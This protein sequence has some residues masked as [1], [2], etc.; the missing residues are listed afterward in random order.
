MAWGYVGVSSVAT[1]AS[2]NIALT[3]PAG[4]ADGDL[5]IACIAYRSNAAFTPPSGAGWTLIEQQ[6]TGN[7][8]AA[9][10]A[11]IASGA[12][13]WKIRSGS[14][15]GTWTRTGG[16]I[17]LGRIIAYD[18]HDPSSPLNVHNSVTLAAGASTTSTLSGITTT[19]ANEL[20]VAMGASARASSFAS[21]DATDPAT[22]SGTGNQTGAPTAGTWLERA[23][24][25]SSTGAD[26]ALALFDGVRATAGATGNIIFNTNL[27]GRHALFAASFKLAPV[28]YTL[29]AD[30]GSFALTGVA[31][32]L[33]VG[34]KLTAE[35]GSFAL[36]GVA[37]DLVYDSGAGAYALTADAGSFALAGQAA[38]LLVGR[39]IAASAGAFT[40]T[41]RAAG[42]LHGSKLTASAG[43]F[44]LTGV[45]ADLT[46]GR[47]ITAAAGAFTLSG[48]A[49]G[50]LYGRRLTAGAGA[51]TLSG[52]AVTL[53]KGRTLAVEAG[54]FALT[55]FAA[56]LTRTR[57]LAAGVGAFALSGQAVGLLAGRKL[58]S[59]VGSYA[60]S[61]QSA[62]L[63]IGRRLAAEAGAFAV[64]GVDAALT[65]TP[66]SSPTL[67]AEPG[68]FVFVGG[69]AQL[70][71]GS[72][73]V[74]LPFGAGGGV[75]PSRKKL[76]QFLDELERS[77]E[78][79]ER[80]KVQPPRPAQK[81]PPSTT[82]VGPIHTSADDDEEALVWILQSMV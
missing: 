14:A 58:A 80:K 63:L 65:Y 10:S 74:N 16:D 72:L 51:F 54:A 79:K 2:G 9:S 11:S 55:G 13:W 67:V 8:T 64:T 27:T 49:S 24:S 57:A 4:A 22:Q 43:A 30:A 81:R 69:D 59:A 21:V 44:A 42:L 48:Q 33:T 3:E 28:A 19:Q 37:A 76:N 38:S 40:L 78:P 18:G 45:A 15:A 17:A 50:L 60:L 56:T 31:A 68:A 62:G 52:Q 26:V 41:G 1:A 29:T 12:M 53:N 6:N 20:I 39:K 25:S 32:G 7:T 23:D 47:H 36:T 77:R 75:A 35:A 70:R 82:A 34:R 5:M 73:S 46:V 71:Y 66:S 61:G